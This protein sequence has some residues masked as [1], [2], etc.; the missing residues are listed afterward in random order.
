VRVK[1]SSGAL[2]SA[3]LLQVQAGVNAA[4]V[5]N[6][7]GE[8]EVLQFLNATLVDAGT[9]ELSGL[10]RGQVGTEGAMRSAVAAGAIFVM[11]D[12]ALARIPLAFSDLKLPLNWRCGPSNRDIGDAS[13]VVSPHAFQGLGLR[14]LSPC[15]VK[16]RRV[17]GGDITISWL[18]RTR[19][20]G[21]NW[22]VTDVPLGE[23]SERYEVDVM[24]GAIVKRTIAAAA[25]SFVYSAAQQTADFGA[26]QAS[27]AVR[28]YQMSTLFGRGAARAATL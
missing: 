27:V 8:W 11:F 19:I 4:A 3:P 26:T 1:L 16:G 12:A 2:F 6:A 7:D 23:D 13:Y 15:R 22:E 24:S 25:P 18:R 14:P 5:Q 21:D 28:I 20:G 9:Y 10:L 17:V